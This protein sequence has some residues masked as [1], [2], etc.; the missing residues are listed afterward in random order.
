MTAM[1]SVA[2]MVRTGMRRPELDGEVGLDL[3]EE[4]DGLSE[5]LRV[6]RSLKVGGGGDGCVER[7]AMSQGKPDL[8]GLFIG[9]DEEDEKE[10]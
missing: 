2:S 8:K 10:A 9:A 6:R 1:V 4:G 7:L 5:M 3:V